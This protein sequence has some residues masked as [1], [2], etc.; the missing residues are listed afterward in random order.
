MSADA[1]S[2]QGSR[3]TAPPVERETAPPVT[4]ETAPP[5]GV[6]APS[7]AAPFDGE[8]ADA[9]GDASTNDGTISADAEGD[10]APTKDGEAPANAEGD[11]PV[12]DTVSGYD[13][14][15]SDENA[16]EFPETAVN[17]DV[18][19]YDQESGNIEGTED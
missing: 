2:S 3:E 19:T 18:T 8:P 1:P 15:E 16:A 4:R 10:A 13:A 17:S 11:A 5:V 7:E 9:Q 14:P 12:D 6:T